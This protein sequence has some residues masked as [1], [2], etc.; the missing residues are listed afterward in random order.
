MII[1][2]ALGLM[3]VVLFILVIFRKKKTTLASSLASVLLAGVIALSGYGVATAAGKWV[4]PSTVKSLIAQVSSPA[5]PVEFPLIQQPATV[6]TPITW[7]ELV[8]FIEDDHTNWNKYDPVK[9]NCL[10]FAVDLVANAHKQNIQAW[11]VAVEFYNEPVGHAFVGFETTDR[12]IVYVEPQ[13]DNTY[14]DL[15]V[16]QWLCDSWGMYTCM[17]KIKTVTFEQC[18]HARFCT[19]YTPY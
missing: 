2:E 10:D 1:L 3:V 13:G 18:D 7:K 16:G 9:Y 8:K 6:Y 17:G 5:N 14:N 19:P 4:N 12:G 15:R 11:V